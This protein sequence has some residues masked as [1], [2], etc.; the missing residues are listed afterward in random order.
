MPTLHSCFDQ[1]DLLI[2]DLS[3]PVSDFIATLKPYA[4]TDTDAHTPVARAAYP[5]GPEGDGVDDLLRLL[6]DPARDA[7]RAARHELKAYL[8]GPTAPPSTQRF[9]EAVD[10]LAAKGEAL[11]R[12]RELQAIHEGA[13]DAPDAPDEHRPA[14][15]CTCAPSA[16]P[17]AK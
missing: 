4:L 2:S 1:A 10:A 14:A 11:V 9:N 17:P 15:P 8:L 6:S 3:G 16:P 7:L 13:P 5:L 12:L